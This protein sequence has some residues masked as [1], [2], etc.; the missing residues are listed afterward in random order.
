ME[1]KQL[2]QIIIQYLKGYIYYHTNKI[3]KK[4]AHYFGANSVLH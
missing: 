3:M 1:V 4:I 2:I